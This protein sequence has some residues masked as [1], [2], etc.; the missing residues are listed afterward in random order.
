MIQVDTRGQVE[1]VE[2]TVRM[3]DGEETILTT[4]SLSQTY[5]T[6][7]EDLWEACSQADRLARWFAPVSGELK[8]GG[9]FQVEGNAGGTIKECDPPHG[10]TATWEFGGE[11]SDLAVRV[12]PEGDGRAR[13]TIEHSAEGDA[14]RWAQ[15]GPGAVGVGWDLALLGLALHITTGADAPAETS[16][17]GESDDAKAFMTESSRRWGDASIAAGT[18]ED[19]ARAAE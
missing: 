3:R 4:V 8:L 17:W 6:D 14:E 5:A 16:E 12:T 1:A 7:A 15:F 18:P 11:T 10:F 13:L 2:R 9:R 19:D